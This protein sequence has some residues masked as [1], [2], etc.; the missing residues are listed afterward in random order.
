M[1]LGIG[2]AMLVGSAVAGGTAVAGAKIQSN[3]AKKAQAAQQSATDKALQV[4]QQQNAPYLALGQQGAARLG[5]LA[6]NHQPYTQVFGNGRG[7]Q[8]QPG[9]PMTGLGS[10]G[11]PP[12]TSLAGLGQPPPGAATGQTPSSGMPAPQAMQR[13]PV[14]GPAPMGGRMVLMQAPD[15]SRNSVPESAVS[16]LEARG[17]RRV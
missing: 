11:G 6:A 8:G 4:Q 2:A 1:P 9:Q 15:G 17:A 12:P 5:Q 16:V 10:M 7:A 3:A 13:P 14:A